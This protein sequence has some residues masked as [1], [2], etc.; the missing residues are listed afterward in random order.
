MAQDALGQSGEPM[1]LR[2]YTWKNRLL[3]IFAPSADSPDYQSL[4]DEIQSRPVEV[5]E[6]DIRVFEVLETGES[7]IGSSILGKKSADYLRRT[8]SIG[9]GH[10]VVLLIGKD[11]G[12]KFRR[13]GRVQL[14]EIF[15]VIDGM[16][17]RQREMKE[18]K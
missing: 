15:S 6:R 2:S 9:P 3:I 5:A 11:G 13:Q 4:R 1:D 14:A 17:M 18:R 8:F 16:P 12:E 10:F 7:R